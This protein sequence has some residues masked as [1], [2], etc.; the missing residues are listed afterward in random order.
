MKLLY[1]VPIPQSEWDDPALDLHNSSRRVSAMYCELLAGYRPGALQKLIDNFT[2]FSSDGQDSMVLETGVAWSSLCSHHRLPFTGVA[3]VAYI[4]GARLIGASKI[5][6][7]VQH[8]SLMLQIQ[9]RMGRQIADFIFEHAEAK[10]V[11][12]ML[13]AIHACMAVRGPKQP[14]VKMVTTCIRPAPGG[15][16][17]TLLRGVLSEFYNQINIC[18]RSK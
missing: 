10:M 3:H 9:E 5:P 14:N 17:D 2:T 12:V 1:G 8:F 18:M 6:R 4:P 7:V 16:D 15:E 11:I 13:E